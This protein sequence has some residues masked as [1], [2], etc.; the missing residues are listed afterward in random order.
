M[1]INLAKEYHNRRDSRGKLLMFSV[2]ILP[3]RDGNVMDA[4]NEL[5]R[6]G[7]ELTRIKDIKDDLFLETL[8]LTFHRW[9]NK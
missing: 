1:N 2:Q 3:E 7:W 5:I 4:V 6:E 8:E 9:I